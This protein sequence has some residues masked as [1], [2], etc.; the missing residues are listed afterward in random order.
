LQEAG[1]RD[2]ADTTPLLI[3]MLGYQGHAECPSWRGA[4][5]CQH[6]DYDNII[7]K[8]KACVNIL[9]SHF[10]TFLTNQEKGRVP[11]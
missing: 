2:E 1:G 8:T 10:F 7:S 4:L 3:A 5:H 11:N 6:S 9:N